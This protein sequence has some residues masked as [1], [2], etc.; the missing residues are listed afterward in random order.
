MLNRSN[1]GR[2]LLFSTLLG[3]GGLGGG[4]E[5]MATA[6]AAGAATFAGTFGA[7]KFLLANPTF[8]KWLATG[9]KIGGGQAALSAHLG[10]LSSVAAIEPQLKDA[11]DQYEAA[12]R[13]AMPQAQR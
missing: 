3:G 8:A 1:T 12:V 11:I 10:R 13:T 4:V 5:G 9:M 6:A 2:V 7:A